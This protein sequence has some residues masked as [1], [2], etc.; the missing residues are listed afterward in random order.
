M[1]LTLKETPLAN[2]EFSDNLKGVLKLDQCTHREKIQ[3]T[4]L[5]RRFE[6]RTWLAGNTANHGITLLSG[7]TWHKMIK[8]L[9]RN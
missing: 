6:L 7:K 8:H 5:N 1:C 2:L 3:T 4:H 9:K